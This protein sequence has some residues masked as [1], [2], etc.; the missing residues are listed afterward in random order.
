[1][2]AR[3][4]S[5]HL[6]AVPSI[7]RDSRGRPTVQVVLSL[8]ANVLFTYQARRAAAAAAREAAAQPILRPQVTHLDIFVPAVDAPRTRSLVRV[9]DGQM[10]PGYT[11]AS[12]LGKHLSGD[13]LF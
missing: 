5:A 1:M 4:S 9:V 11:H 6:T 8:G 13:N 12:L 10:D 7:S 3:F 2:A